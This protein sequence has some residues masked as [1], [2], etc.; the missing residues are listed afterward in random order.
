MHF[1]FKY[2]KNLTYFKIMKSITVLFP[3]H[4]NLLM[5]KCHIKAK[6]HHFKYGQNFGNKPYNLSSGFRTCS[7][8]S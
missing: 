5:T 2:I 4:F 1:S 7:E 3:K 6:C 8:L